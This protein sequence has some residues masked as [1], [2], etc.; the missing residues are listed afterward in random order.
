[1]IPLIILTD[2]VFYAF[3]SQNYIKLAHLN[4]HNAV[5]AYF[6]KQSK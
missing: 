6:I 1:M 3:F 2:K 5:K 4:L